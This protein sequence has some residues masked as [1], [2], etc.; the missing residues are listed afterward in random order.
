MYSKHYFKLISEYLY[1]IIEVKYFEFKIVNFN[2]RRPFTN[3]FNIFRSLYTL[4]DYINCVFK[5]LYLNYS[6][7]F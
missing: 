2:L 4:I 7:Q 5:A 6:L 3:K 1:S